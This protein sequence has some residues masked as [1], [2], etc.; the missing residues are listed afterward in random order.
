MA[1]TSCR[2]ARPGLLKK[3]WDQINN[4]L[5]IIL[6]VAAVISM[7]WARSWTPCAIMAIVVL[8]CRSSGRRA[9]IPRREGLAA[10]S[11]WRRQRQ[12][13][14]DGVQ[15]TVPAA[16]CGRRPGACWRAGNYVPADL[17]LGGD[18]T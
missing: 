18:V 9:R 6:I 11:A 16:S 14:R 13:I 4:Y 17:R 15:V 7:A 2:K 5:I 1:P 10:L 8:K 12:V 3:L